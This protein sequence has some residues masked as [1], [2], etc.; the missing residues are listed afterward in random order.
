M[1]KYVKIQI[2]A[3][4]YVFMFVFGL[5]PLIYIG[6]H[7]N[8]FTRPLQTVSDILAAIYVGL[9]Y[10]FIPF[11]AMIAVVIFAHSQSDDSLSTSSE[12]TSPDDENSRLFEA[13]LYQITTKKESYN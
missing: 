4:I 1:R 9:V 8:D 13:K 5:W 10:F 7:I 2:V 12:D 6:S 3:G 11:M